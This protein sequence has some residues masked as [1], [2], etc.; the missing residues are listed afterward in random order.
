MLFGWLLAL[1]VGIA[2]ACLVHDTDAQRHEPNHHNTGFMS[3]V[4]ASSGLGALA[5]DPTLIPQHFGAGAHDAVPVD[6]GCQSFAATAGPIG[7][8]ALPSTKPAQPDAVITPTSAK[9]VA[10][11]IIS[12][13]YQ[14]PPLG[15]LTRSQSPIFIR[16]LRLTI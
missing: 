2:N 11:P 10:V 4:V 1:G 14:L 15:F 6:F 13:D 5:G 3:M 12:G 16:F 7:G 9:L 8:V